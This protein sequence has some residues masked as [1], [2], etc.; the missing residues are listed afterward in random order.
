LIIQSNF[1]LSY[2]LIYKHNC[3]NIYINFNLNYFIQYYYFIIQFIINC[4]IIT[5]DEYPSLIDLGSILF[6]MYSNGLNFLKFDFEFTFSYY[7]TKYS[8]TCQ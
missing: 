3:D 1:Y 8:I 7:W 6:I 2:P 4:L 5:M